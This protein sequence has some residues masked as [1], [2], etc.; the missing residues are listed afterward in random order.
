MFWCGGWPGGCSNPFSLLRGGLFH[1]TTPKQRRNMTKDSSS[2]IVKSFP[3]SHR[4]LDQASATCTG[5]LWASALNAPHH[6]WDWYTKVSSTA[7]FNL[8]LLQQCLITWSEPCPTNN[9]DWAIGRFCVASLATGHYRPL[10]YGYGFIVHW[11]EMAPFDRQC[12]NCLDFVYWRMSR[13]NTS[14][15]KHMLHDVQENNS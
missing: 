9:D 2:T 4:Q 5:A 12:E 10:G 7:Q 8:S 13:S 11:L 3:K 15:A 1:P 6:K 14:V